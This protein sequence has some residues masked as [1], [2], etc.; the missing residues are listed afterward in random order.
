MVAESTQIDSEEARRYR[1]LAAASVAAYDGVYLVRG[2]RP[3]AREG[4]WPDARRMVIIEFPAIEVAHA[5][6]DSPQYQAALATR[7]GP[8]GRRMLF[9]DGTA[10]RVPGQSV[11]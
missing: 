5:W 7:T 6:Y 9:V 11:Q 8:L 2:G 3:Q 4:D 10:Q 1:E